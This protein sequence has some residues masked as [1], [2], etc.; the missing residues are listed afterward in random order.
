MFSQGGEEVEH[1]TLLRGN[2]RVKESLAKGS[3]PKTGHG[4]Q[5][6]LGKWKMR[7]LIRH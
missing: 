7:N 3:L 2:I 5:T 6:P 1:G 4:D